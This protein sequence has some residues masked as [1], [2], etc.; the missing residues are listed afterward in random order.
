METRIIHP[1]NKPMLVVGFLFY[2]WFAAFVAFKFRVF[3]IGGEW[4]NL[5][6]CD[7]IFMVGVLTCI[8]VLCMGYAYYAWILSADDFLQRLRK[9]AFVSKKLP[10]S[11]FERDYIVFFRYIYPIVALFAIMGIGFKLFSIIR[12]C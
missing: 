4:A 1:R 5:Q 7:D 8:L 11:G 12:S 10:E 3:N 2:I 9:Q 6:I